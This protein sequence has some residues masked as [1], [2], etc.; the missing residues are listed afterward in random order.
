ML[1]NEAR[2]LIMAILAIYAIF[3][4]ENWIWMPVM[5]LCSL[6]VLGVLGWISVHKMS[7]VMEWLTIHFGTHFSKYSV[8]LQEQTLEAINKLNEKLY[9]GD[10]K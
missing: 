2:Y 7:K 4:I 10:I 8:E 1:L 9:D 5:F 3:K 6:P